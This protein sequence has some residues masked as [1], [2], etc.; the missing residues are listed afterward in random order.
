MRAEPLYVL[1]YGK[2]QGRELER[3][4]HAT[5]DPALPVHG[6]DTATRRDR[7][8]GA[9]AQS[10]HHAGVMANKAGEPHADNGCSRA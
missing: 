3:R 2:A 1:S 5:P 7:E 10:R 4:T 6:L 8:R 9:K